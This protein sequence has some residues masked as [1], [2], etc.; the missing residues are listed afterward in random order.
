M[1][2]PILAIDPGPEKSGWVALGHGVMGDVCENDALRSM[3]RGAGDCTLAVEMMH[4]RGQLLSKDGMRTL[5]E[6][7][8]MLEA[9]GRDWIDVTREEAKM[10][11]CRDRRA[12]DPN[13]RQAL[14]D[15][16]G[17]DRKAIGGKK[18]PA[19][20]GKGWRGR[21][22]PTCAECGGSG[23]ELPPGPLYHVASHQWAALAVAVTA[24][25]KIEQQETTR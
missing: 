6:L 22:R 20:K 14:I 15:L 24:K 17:G 13:I 2:T 19:C 9:W 8:R 23:W 11:L 3:L 5:V 10:H 18:C 16:W 25:A 21:G 12:K 7:G 4:P 1:T